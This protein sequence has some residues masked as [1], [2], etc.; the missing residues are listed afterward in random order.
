M[1]FRPQDTVIWNNQIPIS[2]GRNLTRLN[3]PRY[4][5]VYGRE[6]VSSIPATVHPLPRP[7]RGGQGYDHPSSER[8]RTKERQVEKRGLLRVVQARHSHTDHSTIE[9]KEAPQVIH[10]QRAIERYQPIT[11][12]QSPGLLGGLKAALQRL[13]SMQGK[14]SEDAQVL[15]KMEHIFGQL[16]SDFDERERLLDKKLATL[17]KMQAKETRMLKWFSIPLTLL[18]MIGLSFLF[19]IAYSMQ[20]SVAGMS[21]NMGTMSSNISSMTTNTQDMSSNMSHM[22]GSMHNMSNNMTHMGRDV[23]YMSKNVGAMSRSV[24]P[25]GQ[26]AESAAPMMGMMRS[27]MPF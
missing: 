5:A 21:A 8:Y 20:T 13:R 22:T 15:E 24:A 7:V 2:C 23:S 26:A 17:E 16:H 14:H 1:I 18:A 12:Q 4:D 19:Y 27:F 25:M 9:P 11:A 6:L 10:L 3:H